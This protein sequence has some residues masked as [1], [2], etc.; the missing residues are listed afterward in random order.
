MARTTVD[1]RTA[2]DHAIAEL[3]DLPY[4]VW[5]EAVTD[6]SS[7]TRPVPG[8]GSR[9]DIEAD[10]HKGTDDIHVTITLTRGWRRGL[11]DGFTITPTNDFR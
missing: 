6:R 11:T 10:W 3:R 1:S 4:S 9:L 5:R 7:C 2:L 8:G